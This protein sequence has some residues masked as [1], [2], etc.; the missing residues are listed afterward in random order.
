MAALQQTAG[1][2]SEAQLDVREGG[3]GAE[4]LQ[5]EVRVWDR[6]E[7][8]LIEQLTVLLDGALEAVCELPDRAAS[9]PPG[10]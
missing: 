9:P 2:R 6:R 3:W 1:S 10:D 5:A 8:E 4:R 7:Q